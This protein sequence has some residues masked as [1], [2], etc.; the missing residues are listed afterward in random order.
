M[1]LTLRTLLAYLDD[2]LDPNEIKQIGQKAAESDAAQELIARIKQVTRRRRLTAPPLTG[3]GAKVDAN[4]IADYLD[5]VLP[6]EE[7]AELEKICLESDVHLAE[8]AA[9]HQ[10]LT[11]ILGEPALVPPTARQRMYTLVRGREAIPFRKARAVAPV[12]RNVEPA[13][14]EG[15]DEDDTLMGL[16]VG[17]GGGWIKWLIPISALGLLA[18]LAFVLFQALGPGAGTQHA[19]QTRPNAVTAPES[20]R[21]SPPQT[22]PDKPDP[23]KPD[24]NKP[25]PNAT[26]PN[27]PDPN[28]PDPNKPDPNKPDPNKPDPNVPAREVGKVVAVDP[29][30]PS[31]MV[32]QVAK[33]DRAE[34]QQLKPD[35]PV[36]TGDLLV[37]LPGFRGAVRG[38]SGVD[39]MLW[40][41]VPELIRGP[42][43]ESAVRLGTP[44][45]V[46]DAGKPGDV[47]L[48]FTLDRGR[49]VVTNRKDE[50][51]KVRFH[52]NETPT[53]PR[54]ETWEVTLKTKGSEFAADLQGVYLAD[55]GFNPDP[56]T[57]VGPAAAL[58]LVIL[59]GQASVKIGPNVYEN[60]EAHDPAKP[61]ARGFFFWDSVGGAAKLEAI[62]PQV[63][64][65]WDK[66]FPDKAPIARELE[67]LRG[68][69][70][71]GQTVEQALEAMLLNQNPQDPELTP[72]LAVY[73]LGALDELPKL[74]DE[75]E[76]QDERRLQLRAR[77][78][79]TLRHWMARRVENDQI[80]FQLLQKGKRYSPNQATTVMQLLHDQSAQALADRQTWE[81][82][83]D[84]L[85]H[86]KPGIR[87]LA[88]WQL[89]RMVPEAQKDPLKYSPS[90]DSQKQKAAYDEWQKLLKAGKI[91]PPP[92]PR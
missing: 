81:T 21:P 6:A 54:P 1:R 63:L 67:G 29:P 68:R 92:P 57:A 34:W 30:A 45:S 47:D 44:R 74:L 27:K 86:E 12:G 77:V 75:L 51:A 13:A 43:M 38:N 88:F 70:N 40:G 78:I 5:N 46:A 53:K 79:H 18:L 69:V 80:L 19:Q 49:V 26:D 83:I 58:F 17:K 41:N 33:G 56:K 28:K 72:G 60:L 23:N 4:T 76:N 9:C 85:K 20:T 48:E 3:S 61:P 91:P 31:L 82:L 24:P 89:L 55:V 73:C 87:E 8:V 59:K 16:P 42:I 50:P 66:T 32:R 90:G 10:I 15:G 35:M 71:G 11:L 52:F 14:P 37:A 65:A 2:T 39:L 64:V 62:N 22:N 36:S 84:Y 25:D 7:V